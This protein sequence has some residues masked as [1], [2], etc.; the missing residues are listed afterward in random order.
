MTAPS[1]NQGYQ[2]EVTQE[3]YKDASGSERELKR[4][5]ETVETN[6][7][8]YN[9]GYI[10]GRAAERSY[11]KAN[12]T[13]RDNNNAASGL[14][15]GLLLAS[16]AALVGGFLWYINLRDDVNSDRVNPVV[17]PTPD[18]PE[19]SPSPEVKQES[20]KETTIIEKIKE[21]PVEVPVQVPVEV[22]V[23]VPTPQPEAPSQTST[24]SPT[25]ETTPSQAQNDSQS[26]TNND[27][28]ATSNSDPTQTN[29]KP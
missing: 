21:V 3:T 29:Q 1:E 6:S 18:K 10:H 16:L 27:R 15:I 28:D 24:P 22:P 9:N 17:V 19:A 2:K 20:K 26:E 14:L 5:S 23:V 12:L 8:R 13:E 11:Q 25:A 4:V 7:D